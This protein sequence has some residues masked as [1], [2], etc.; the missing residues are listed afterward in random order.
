[1]LELKCKRLIRQSRT[2]WLN[3]VLEDIKRGGTGKKLK[4][5][6]LGRERRLDVFHPLK[7]TSL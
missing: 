6:S 1:M 5:K 3:Q 2:R 7:F 4:K